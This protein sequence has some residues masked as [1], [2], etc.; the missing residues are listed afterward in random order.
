MPL[1]FAPSRFPNVDVD[2][3]LTSALVSTE[4]TT[5]GAMRVKP[6]FE[7]TATNASSA[8]HGTARKSTIF[9]H[10]EAE[11]TGQDATTIKPTWKRCAIRAT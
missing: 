4:G 10:A 5:I 8:V 3:A 7:E 9:T 1:Q 11:D 2:G 6:L